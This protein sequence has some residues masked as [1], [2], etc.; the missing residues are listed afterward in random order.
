MDAKTPVR[1][2]GSYLSPYVRKVLVA[3][4]LEGIPYSNDPVVAFHGNDASSELSPLR[5]VPVL[6]EEFADTR[7]GDESRDQEPRS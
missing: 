3:L 5:R 1:I 4:D 6:I 7:M 2:I